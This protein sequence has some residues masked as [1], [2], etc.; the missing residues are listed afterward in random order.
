MPKTEFFDGVEWQSCC[1]EGAELTAQNAPGTIIPITGSLTISAGSVNMTLGAELEALSAFSQTGLMART[2]VGAYSGRTLTA[3]AGI[4]IT[5][6]NGVA[7]NPTIGLSTINLTGSVTGSGTNSIN[8]TLS[9]AQI[10][11]SNSLSFDWSNSGSFAEY[12]MY[13][14]LEDATTPPHFVH[15]VQSGSG[16]TYRRWLT[17]YKPGFGSQPTG[18]YQ[19]E[20]YHAVNGHQYPFEI[21]TY[22]STLRT[23]LRTTVDVDNNT[24][25]NALDPV[26]S[27]DVA[28]KS[29][30][31]SVAGGTSL[32]SNEISVNTSGGSDHWLRRSGQT[33]SG[34]TI[35]NQNSNSFLFE[36]QI[37]E[38]AGLA[39]NGDSDG[40]TIWSP[41]D[42]GAYLNIQDEDKSNSRQ[43][44]VNTSGS[45]IRVS[46]KTRKHSIQDKT[47]NNVLDRFLQ[48]SVK[49]YGYKYSIPENISEKALS[50]INKKTNKMQV[51]LI[52]EELFKVFPNCIPDYY[53]SLFQDKSSKKSLNLKEEIKDISNSGIDYNALLCYFIMAFQEYIS[54]TNEELSYLKKTLKKKEN[55]K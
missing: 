14:T 42:S 20:F 34:T 38:S 16:S 2:G 35:Y 29:Y 50:R 31:D 9:G 54:K 32:A 21:G 18:S 46:S 17:V 49:S 33:K 22:G 23:Y 39:V 44:Y 15:G 1:D 7:G 27:Q 11:D 6:G 24:I 5:N 19:L 45:W 13:H 53:N 55:N 25:I 52:L 36:Q 10:M 48:L 8:T 30:V 3:G 28:T 26:S 37:G 41:G 51:G 43:A 4:N 40:C 12:S 47:N